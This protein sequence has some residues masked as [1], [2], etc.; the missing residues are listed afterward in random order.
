MKCPYLNINCDKIDT[1]DMTKIECSECE[2]SK[3]LTDVDLKECDCA[4][5]NDDL[6][7]TCGHKK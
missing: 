6:A 5:L 7:C 1:L 2:K 3:A 4:K